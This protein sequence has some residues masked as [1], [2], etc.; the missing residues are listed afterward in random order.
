[1]IHEKLIK[2]EKQNFRPK[3]KKENKTL[4]PEVSLQTQNMQH[5]LMMTMMMQ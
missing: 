2:M 4:V 5:S 1:M 3:L